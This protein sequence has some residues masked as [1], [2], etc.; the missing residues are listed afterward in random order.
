MIGKATTARSLLAALAFAACGG[1]K[2]T[3]VEPHCDPPD[4]G[5]LTEEAA[6]AKRLFDAEKWAAAANA[7]KRVADGTTRDDQGNRQI[8]AYH[9]GIALYRAG[10]QAESRA[11]FET[12]AATTCHLKQREAENWLRQPEPDNKK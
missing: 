9:R 12:V 8:A 2:K 5:Q 6:Q 4:V 3:A 11:Q 7:L 1:E 10:Q